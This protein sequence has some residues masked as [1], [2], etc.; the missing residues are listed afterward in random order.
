MA[1]VEVKNR[2]SPDEN[3]DLAGKGEAG[4]FDVGGHSVLYAT[5]QPGWRWT[6]D[7]TPLVG[8]DNCKATHLMYCIS[9]RMGIKHDDGTEVEIGPGDIVSVEPGHDAWIVGDEP[10]TLVDFGGFRQYGLSTE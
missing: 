6:E 5:F 10:C 9:G 8:T 3:R 2:N 1:G 4:V 7:M